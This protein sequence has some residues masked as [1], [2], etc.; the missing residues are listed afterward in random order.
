MNMVTVRRDGRG[1]KVTIACRFTAPSL[2][3]AMIT[4]VMVMV[5][6]M[7]RCAGIMN[8]IV[9]ASDRQFHES[10]YFRMPYSPPTH[11]SPSRVRERNEFQRRSYSSE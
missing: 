9:C 2:Q 7:V 1:R 3:A 4:V 10:I 6:M 11:D 8:T 5:V